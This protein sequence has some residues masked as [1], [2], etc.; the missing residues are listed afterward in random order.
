MKTNFAI[1]VALFTSCIFSD[2]AETNEIY[3]TNIDKFGTYPNFVSAIF[4]LDKYSCGTKQALP[5]VQ[6]ITGKKYV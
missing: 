5:C 2:V 4:Y 6:K 3:P 1:V